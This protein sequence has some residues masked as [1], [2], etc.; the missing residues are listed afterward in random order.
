M[1]RELFIMIYA[2]NIF[3]QLSQHSGQLDRPTYV[4][5]DPIRELS[6]Q[7]WSHEHRVVEPRSPHAHIRKRLRNPWQR[8]K[9]YGSRNVQ[10][11]WSR[12]LHCTSP[13]VRTERPGTEVWR[14][15]QR[16]YVIMSY[17]LQFLCLCKP[18]EQVS[19]LCCRGE[20]VFFS[21][22]SNSEIYNAY[23]TYLA[24]RYE[25]ASLHTFLD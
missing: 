21:T 12:R 2:I 1:K 4:R 9:T 7:T 15:G 24:L 22:M 6:P 14:T 8:L 13:F 16:F 19:R 17:G 10:Y 3:V 23:C 20:V 5:R 18:R 11:K 25:G